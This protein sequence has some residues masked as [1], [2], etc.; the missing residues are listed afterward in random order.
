MKKLLTLITAG[1]AGSALLAQTN[2]N[3]LLVRDKLGNVRGFLVERID[4]IFFAQGNDDVSAKVSSVLPEA[5]GDT[6]FLQVTV[7]RSAGCDAFKLACV[8]S[9]TAES[10]GSDEAVADYVDANGGEYVRQQSSEVRM[11]IPSFK[12]SP[13][14]E[15]TILSVGYDEYG[16]ACG[17]DTCNFRTPKGDA[18]QPD[19]EGS[20]PGEVNQALFVLYPHAQDVEWS[21]RENYYVAVFSLPATRRAS[22]TKPNRNSAWFDQTGKWYMTEND[23]VFLQS[24]PQAVQAAF[25]ASEY[26]GWRIDDIDIIRRQGAETVYVIEVEGVQDGVQVEMDLYYSE[27]GVLVRQLVDVEEDYDYGDFIPSQPATGI[28]D[29]INQRYP[30]ARIIEIDREDGGMT[31]VEIL[32]G[33]KC[34][35]LLFDKAGQWIHTKT[36]TAYADVPDVVKTTLATS[37]EYS[38]Y[39]IDDIDYYETPAK[40][41]Y[42]FE[43]KSL[44]VEVKVEID[45]DGNMEGYDPAKPGQG[46]QGGS[47]P[48]NGGMVAGDKESFI[49]E[50]YPGAT[51]REYDYDDDGLIEVEIIHDGH[52]KDVYFNGAGG[53]VMTRWEVW[54]KEVPA[55]VTNAYGTKY[56]GYCPDE[57]E[58]VETPSG[59]YYLVELE[60]SGDSELTLRIDADGNILGTR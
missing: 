10:L 31:E 41:Y 50:K 36:E 43:L 26:A 2:P 53:W 34:R 1:I 3:R 4:S 23:I 18:S 11:A 45:E 49:Q 39:R 20:I 48:G 47:D 29:F 12:L 28:T 59:N 46:G 17:T 19:V 52:E 25:Q 58:Y 60:G 33:R 54:Q 8:P 30:G 22:G 24:L 42:R 6:V 16:I 27:D 32:D 35:E 5:K 44:Y 9:G 37:E 14:T 51:I 40:N 13:D 15:Y 7:T 21:Q 57:I 38:S 56:P 55:A